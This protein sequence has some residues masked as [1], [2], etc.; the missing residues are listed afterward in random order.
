LKSSLKRNNGKNVSS[1]ESPSAALKSSLKRN[2]GKNVSSFESPSSV[3]KM[4][5]RKITPIKNI[6]PMIANLAIKGRCISVWHSHKLN[7]KHDP[8]SLDFVFQDEESNRIQIFVKNELMFQFEPLLQEGQCYIISKFG[9]AENSGRLPLLSNRWK[10]SFFKG[11]QV[12]RIEQIDNNFIGFVNEPLTRILD[13][14]NEYHEHDC[15]D[16]IGTVV[17][18]GNIISVNGHG[19]SKVRR[20]VNRNKIARSSILGPASSTQYGHSPIKL[21]IIHFH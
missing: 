20:T 1:F 4:N 10:I 5:E 7:E 2:N 18:I 9:A 3:L 19:C 15:V 16:V 6:N 14:N 17:S 13:T 21:L 12:T 8:Y 11:T